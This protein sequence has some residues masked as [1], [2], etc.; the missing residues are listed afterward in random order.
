MPRRAPRGLI[1]AGSCVRVSGP[2][3]A[4]RWGGYASGAPVFP[5]FPAMFR[6]A[7]SLCLLVTSLCGVALAQR[8]AAALPESPNLL[9]ILL[10][11]WGV[12]RFD[13]YTPGSSART[14]V[15]DAIAEQSLVFDRA[16]SDPTCSPTRSA[17]MTGTLG[18]HTGVGN[19]FPWFNTARGT[20]VLD[21][22][23]Y[24]SLPSALGRRGYSNFAIG[25]WHLT[26]MNFA[27]SPYLHPLAFG[28]DAHYGLITNIVLG[29]D[30][31]Y[32]N[33]EY[34]R[35][36]ASGVA[37]EPALAP[38]AQS[39]YVTTRQVDDAL[40]VIERAG[41]GPWFTWLALTAPHM[42]WDLPPQEL[43]TVDV[44]SIGSLDGAAQYDV[45]LEAADT[46]IGRLLSSVRPEVLQNTIVIVMGDNGTP[47]AAFNTIQP[48]GKK[49][50]V[51]EGGI[52][53]PLMVWRA[54][55]APG[56]S[57]ALVHAVDLYATL[58]E[59]ADGD[60]FTLPATAPDSHSFAPLL[61]GDD[62]T[63]RDYVYSAR[64]KPV[65]FGPFD[66][67]RRAVRRDGWKLIRNT[68]GPTAELR[69]M[70]LTEA[71]DEGL[72]VSPPYSA[73]EQAAFCALD[74]IFRELEGGDPASSCSGS[75]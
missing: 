37:I 22:A 8:G 57:D 42:P 10:D 45:V 50:T 16:Y 11:D 19:G 2:A 3:V 41:A 25:K 43:V 61:R 54:N 65:G 67:E 58:I 9:V 38:P 53:V 36:D 32:Y 51:D 62:F 46:E 73:E 52:H 55:M 24:R 48:E 60:A 47:G 20:H 27:P 64:R 1:H 44:N 21:P 72:A 30:L 5:G 33:Y 40:E 17:I 59:L 66:H 31:S 4:M 14:P 49:A 75:P 71:G 56:R 6:V 13:A 7:L 29:M 26:A 28:F 15:L 63:P 39:T 70:D 34:V 12:D 18:L 23:A 68:D 35:A 69:R 74:A